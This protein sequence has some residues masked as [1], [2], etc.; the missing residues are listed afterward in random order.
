LSGDSSTTTFVIWFTGISGAGKSTI[1]L[2]VEERLGELG[3]S[4][5]NLDGDALRHGLN[6]DLGFSDEDRAENIR[7]VGELARLFNNNGM[8]VLVAAISPFREGRD[9]AR[10]LAGPG[11]FVEVHVDTPLEIAE[12]RDVKGL[13]KK[14][15]SGQLPNF[16]GIDSPYEAPL[17][18]EVRIDASFETPEDAADEVFRV[19]RAMGLVPA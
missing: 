1:A 7:R 19:L 14:A 17:H 4:V 11:R 8:I 9:A 13:Y 15:R 16:T 3:L 6:R 10:E 5:H 2:I 18:P 12:Q